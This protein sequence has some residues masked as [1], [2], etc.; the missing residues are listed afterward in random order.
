MPDMRVPAL[1]HILRRTLPLH[2]SH[3]DIVDNA[4]RSLSS[5]TDEWWHLIQSVR[6]RERGTWDV[7]EKSKGKVG[8]RRTED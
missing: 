7:E 8:I 3:A 1:R 4:Y 6:E 2:D 5:V